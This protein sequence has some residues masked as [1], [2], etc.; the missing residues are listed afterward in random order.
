MGLPRP[1][2][3]AFVIENGVLLRYAGPGGAVAVPVGVTAIGEKAFFCC[4]NLTELRISEGVQ[5]IGKEAFRGCRRLARLTLPES[6]T[7]IGAC[8]FGECEALPA[9]TLPPRLPAVPERLFYACARLRSVTLPAGLTA[10]AD[11]AFYDCFTLLRAALPDSLTRIGDGAFA[12]CMALE[13]LALP[14]GLTSIG[15][16]AFRGCA[17]L[18]ALRVPARVTALGRDAFADCA[19]LV[20]A[21]VPELPGVFDAFSGCT[22]LREFVLPPGARRCK[23]VDG[24]VLSAD[25]T[26]LLAYP[27]GRAC[28]RYDVPETVVELGDGI[29]LHAP[30]ALVVLHPGVKRVSPTAADCR[31]YD[32]PYVA[33]RDPAFTALLGRPV[34]LGPVSDLSNRYKRRA[35]EGFLFAL[36]TGLP[37]MA[38]WRESYVNYIRQERAAWERTAW[39]DE[40]LLRLMSAEGLLSA[41]TRTAMLAKYRAAGRA[42]LVAALEACPG[43]A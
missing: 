28:A 23:S 11:E 9:L 13:E 36:R 25:G 20:R 31:G 38:P 35:V 14:D 32:G 10:I 8:A 42:D 2:D 3:R 24:V 4:E 39:R 30:A 15:D 16:G 7:A 17:G 21:A 40:T 22:R 29:F 5:S 43:E 37:E 12:H 26:R 27:P 33:Y 34:Y 41:D 6:L 1:D 19:G 18:S